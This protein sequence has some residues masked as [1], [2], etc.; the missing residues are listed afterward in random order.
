MCV[1]L[2]SHTFFVNTPKTTLCGPR[3]AWI[4]A[5]CGIKFSNYKKIQ[6]HT[7]SV[8]KHFLFWLIQGSFVCYLNMCVVC[9]SANGSRR[10]VYIFLFIYTPIVCVCVSLYIFFTESLWGIVWLRLSFLI[11]NTKSVLFPFSF[12]GG[13]T[14]RKKQNC[15]SIF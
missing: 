4:I 15:E 8:L 14:C 7:L 5:N 13:T 12:E 11:L 2:E 9:I 3:I 10:R 6:T 1:A